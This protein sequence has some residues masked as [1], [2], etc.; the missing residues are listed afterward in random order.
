M[1]NKTKII[2]VTGHRKLFHKASHIK[3]ALR[4]SLVYLRDNKGYD[5]VITG[6]A[7]GFD[8]LV[9]EACIDVGIPFIAYL[10]FENQHE[11]WGFHQQSTFEQLLKQAELVYLVS[12]GPWENWKYLERDKM[13]VEN[14]DLILAYFN[15]DKD[16]GRTGSGTGFTISHAEKQGV[17]WRNVFNLVRSST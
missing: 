16:K 17:P 5:K 14:S 8:T 3:Y 12:K 1:T 11:K 6:M 13:I 2:G 15:E 4:K 7:L 10:P 9:A